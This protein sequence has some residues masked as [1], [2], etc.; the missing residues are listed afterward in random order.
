MSLGATYTFDPAESW[1]VVKLTRAGLASALAHDHVVRA[2]VFSGSMVY[3]P[4]DAAACRVRITIP[5]EDLVVDA[6]ADRE[7]LGTT[8]GPNEDDRQ[9]TRKNMLARD[10]LWA[11]KHP[12]ITYQSTRCEPSGDRMRTTG[13]LIIRGVSREITTTLQISL[14]G[15][16]FAASGQFTVNHTDFG[17]RPYSA[18]FGTIRNADPLEFHLHL[19]ATRQ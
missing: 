12:A 11:D 10:Q 14:E 17:F 3:D 18:A 13:D 5:V 6:A 7:R 8:E 1:L 19:I 15:N 16:R 9:K 2:A 4:Q